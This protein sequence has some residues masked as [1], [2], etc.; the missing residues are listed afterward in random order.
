MVEATPPHRQGRRAAVNPA[1]L[2]ARE[3]NLAQLTA[4]R[5]REATVEAALAD[6]IDAGER[7]DDARQACAR[8]MEALEMSILRARKQAEDVIR[9]QQRV[10]ADA[11]LDIHEAGRT[12]PQLAELLEVTVA[13]ARAM[14]AEG[15]AARTGPGSTDA[16]DAEGP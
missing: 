9:V 12:V 1:L 7:I 10:R 13:V 3:R 6:Y 11:A 16:L 2:A 4:Q 8:Q 14:I 15:R 5:S